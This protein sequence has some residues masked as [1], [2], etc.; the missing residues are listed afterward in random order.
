MKKLIKIYV[1]ISL[2]FSVNIFAQNIEKNELKL[3]LTK[4]FDLSKTKKYKELSSHLISS[5]KN[6]LKVYNFDNKTDAKNVKRIAKKI[7]AYLDLSDSYEYASIV[8]NSFN[9]L[10]SAELKVN[11]R[12]GNQE[13]TISFLFVEKSKKLFLVKFN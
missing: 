4:I 12:S 10:P 9:N 11:F 8:Y 2:L 3:S 1:I 6:D 5:K 13:L 7:K